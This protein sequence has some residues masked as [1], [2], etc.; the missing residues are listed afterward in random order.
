[1]RKKAKAFCGVLQEAFC[2]DGRFNVEIATRGAIYPSDQVSFPCGVGVAAL[3]RS[4]LFGM[5]CINRIHTK[6]DTVYEAENVDFL[7][8]GAVRLTAAL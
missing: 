1:M 5:L 7:V 2:G 6:R 4:K 3:K 8:N